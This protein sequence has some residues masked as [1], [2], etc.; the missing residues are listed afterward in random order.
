MELLLNDV[1]HLTQEEIR[2]SKI[3]FNMHNGR[4][5]PFLERWLTHPDEEK[6][7]GT[8]KACSYWGWQGGR[9]NFSQGQWVF[10]FARMPEDEW[11]LISAA[12]IIDTPT[13]DWATVQV[14]EK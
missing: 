2:K 7:K 12:E 3:E 8:C 9:R 11:L 4:G 6:E 13:N 10:S 14:L 1:L 5:E